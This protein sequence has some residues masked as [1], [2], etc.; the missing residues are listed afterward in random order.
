MTLGRLAEQLASLQRLPQSE[1]DYTLARRYAPII[2][3]D[4]R[5]PFYP[6]AVGYTVFREDSPS[7][8]FPRQ[9]QLADDIAF[10][11]EYAIW[12]DWDIQHLY[13]LEHI[14][15]SI[16]RDGN[17]ADAEASWHGRYHQMRDES[18]LLPLQDGRLAICSE[19]GK[20]AFA[21]SPQQLLRREAQT[22]ASCG[23]RAGLMGVHVTPLFEGLIR[24]ETPL[25]NRLAHTYLE[26]LRFE[27]TFDFSIDFDLRQ[28]A[29]VPWRH[30]FQWIPQRVT[31]WL[32]HLGAT[33]PPERRR[34][35]RI[36]HRGAS[37]YAA[38]NSAEAMRAA[39]ELGADYVEI[40]IRATADHCPVVIHDGGLQ[41]THAVAG[42]VSD[43][44]L[45]ELRRLTATG[46]PILSFD[47]AVQLCRE[48]G[49]G[50]YLDI[51]RLTSKSAR[52]LFESLAARQYWKYAIF[53]SFRPDYLA[54][55]K[56]AC[57]E[58]RTSILFG[59]VD[60]DPVKLAQSVGADFVHPC[61]ENRAAQPH[62]LLTP[63]W[64]ASVRA[65]DLGIVC[66]H[67]ERPAEI[68][69]LMALGVDAICS[70]KP[71]L[72]MRA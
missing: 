61:W 50:L 47:Q 27:P 71:E 63:E 28:A 23:A 66:W 68:A 18:G 6:S 20:H 11:I 72:L 32:D 43:Y 60:L 53:G 64:I 59:A 19:P 25:N 16:D 33:I 8:S 9:I 42:H 48:L 2:R 40:D 24:D 44:S 67:E 34:V 56:A 65:A 3:F 62:K 13:E 46:D 38:E 52:A 15:V 69:A 36:A 54:H 26:R 4:Q 57:P 45:D 1:P 70:D 21:P 14:W 49:L 7:S 12:W 10:V 37:A 22:R 30:L 29:F 35:L 55:I 51:K 41:R 5:E 31:A 58:A 39:A 17:L